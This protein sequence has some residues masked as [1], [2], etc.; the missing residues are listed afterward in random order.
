M[1]K[2]FTF[3]LFV[4]MLSF[5]KAFSQPGCV[6]LGCASAHTAVATD[7]SLPDFLVDGTIDPPGS[8]FN[9]TTTKQVFWEFFFSPLGGDFIQGFFESAGGTALDIDYNVFDMGTTAPTPASLTCPISIAAWTEVAG[10]CNRVGSTGLTTGPGQGV[11]AGF[12][13]GNTLTTVLGHYYAIAISIWQGV[14]NTGVPS[15]NF[16]ATAPTLGGNPLNASNCVAI[17]LPVTLSSFTASANNCTVNLN[18]TSEIESDFNN[19]EVQ[20]SSNGKDFTTVASL[21]AQATSKNYSFQQNNPPQGKAYYR[22]RMVDID[23]NLDY[24][25]TIAMK[26]DCGKRQVFVYPNP[27][28]D[29]LNIN[30][31][32]S[33][34]NST[35]AKL[36]D[37]NGKLIYSNNM[38]SGT[39]T[40]NMLNWPKGI[41]LLQLINTTEVQNIKIIK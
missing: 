40:V 31:T 32:N 22:L 8:C 11:Q 9:G 16:D 29:V 24:S 18:W 27:V 21:P 25:K 10:Q 28:T 37:A 12:N 34:D 39:N 2:I 5:G 15:Y 3:L 20:Y 14:S 6:S 4:S 41:Y 1:K 30:I 26:L 33:Q 17:V 35:R 36:F 23:G 7:G 38:I 19:Y 13:E